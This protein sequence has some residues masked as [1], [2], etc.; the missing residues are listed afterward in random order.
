MS[1]NGTESLQDKFRTATEFKEESTITDFWDFN[2]DLKGATASDTKQN[3]DQK[4]TVEETEDPQTE[5]TKNN[6]ESETKNPKKPLSASELSDVQKA[7]ADTATLMFDQILQVVSTPLVNYKFKK[8]FTDEQRREILQKDLIDKALDQLEE[9]DKI[10]KRKWEREVERRDY[11]IKNIPLN[12]KEEKNVN[13]AFLN[14]F[15]VTGKTMPPEW[16]LAFALTSIT[17]DRAIEVFVD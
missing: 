10:L 15:K 16:L 1:I 4:E 2:E 7:S 5:E 14:Y 6:S 12:E 17:A 8:K 3:Q 11:K 9:Q 13:T